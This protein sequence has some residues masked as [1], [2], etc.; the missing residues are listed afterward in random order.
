MKVEFSDNQDR[1]IICENVD[2]V[3]L[4]TDAY[5]VVLESTARNYFKYDAFRI[6]GVFK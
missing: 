3:F 4:T 1:H 2:H 5:V 6:V